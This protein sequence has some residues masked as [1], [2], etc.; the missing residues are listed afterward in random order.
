MQ[1]LCFALFDAAPSTRV[2]RCGRLAPLSVSG[3]GL[4]KFL[5]LVLA[6]AIAY[7]L[8]KGYK[9]KIKGASGRS[10][11]PANGEDMVRCAQCGVHLPRSESLLSDRAFYCSAEHRRSHQKS[12]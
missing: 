3:R 7:W 8:V 1:A 11:S 10:S 6:F 9:R 2:A 4:A 5:L 12:D